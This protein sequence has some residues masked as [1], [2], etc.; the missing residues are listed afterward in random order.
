MRPKI[1]QFATTAACAF[2]ELWDNGCFEK[3]WPCGFWK[4]AK[5]LFMRPTGRFF[6]R[7]V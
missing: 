4:V 7:M 2:D 3:K 6:G 1:S 5:M